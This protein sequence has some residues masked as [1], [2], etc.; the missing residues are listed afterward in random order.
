MR[1]LVQ[2]PSLWKRTAHIQ[3]GSSL[4]IKI[5]QNLSSYIEVCFHVMLNIVNEE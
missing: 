2:E 5:F 3:G 4:L 1:Q